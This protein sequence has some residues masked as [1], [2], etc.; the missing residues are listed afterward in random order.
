M[1]TISIH[2]SNQSELCA[3]DFRPGLGEKGCYVYKFQEL[4]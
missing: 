3:Y 4:L 1:K 2:I